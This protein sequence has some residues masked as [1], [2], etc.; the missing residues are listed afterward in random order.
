MRESLHVTIIGNTL[1][2]ISATYSGPKALTCVFVVISMVSFDNMEQ[3][4]ADIKSINL[5]DF[6]G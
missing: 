5:V 1:K 6:P 4:E 3:M 2:I